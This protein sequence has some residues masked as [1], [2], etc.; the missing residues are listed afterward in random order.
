MVTLAA[1]AAVLAVALVVG[2]LP[3]IRGQGG[4][5]DQWRPL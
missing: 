2:I 4:D 5:R 1:A 3:G